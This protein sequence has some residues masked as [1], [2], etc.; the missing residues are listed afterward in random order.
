MTLLSSIKD[1][2]GAVPAEYLTKTEEDTDKRL[3]RLLA[4]ATAELNLEGGAGDI[5]SDDDYDDGDDGDEGS[6]YDDDE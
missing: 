1:K 2:H 6:D 3:I 5:A 4:I